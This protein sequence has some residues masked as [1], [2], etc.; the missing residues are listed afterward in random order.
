MP[1]QNRL[2]QSRQRKTWARIKGKN[3]RSQNFRRFLFMSS[4]LQRGHCIVRE[5][6]RAKVFGL[7]LTRDGWSAFLSA[8][9][10]LTIVGCLQLKEPGI[11][12][13]GCDQLVVRAGF[14][15]ASTLEHKDPVS[16]SDS[17]KTMRDQDSHMI[18]SEF[19]EI[20]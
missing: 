17:G 2:L 6:L 16:H 10:Y 11:P 7:M 5:T 14:F 12:A 13:P 1:S 3:K 4:D 8:N 9:G 20:V 15:D 18:A 19:L